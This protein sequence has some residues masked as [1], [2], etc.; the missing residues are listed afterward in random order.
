MD[1]WVCNSKIVTLLKT[2][3]SFFFSV[4]LYFLITLLT[5]R[6]LSPKFSSVPLFAFK[7]LIPWNQ[8]L[9]FLEFE[10]PI[11]ILSNRGLLFIKWTTIY[12]TTIKPEFWKGNITFSKISILSKNLHILTSASYWYKIILTTITTYIIWTPGILFYIV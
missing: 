3:L 9:I 8:V 5:P 12:R 7:L 4:S 6:C 1:K 2:T 10:F 11:F